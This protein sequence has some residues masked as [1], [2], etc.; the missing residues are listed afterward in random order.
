MQDM[1]TRRY[2]RMKPPEDLLVAWQT[3]TQKA[4]SRVESI[5]LGGLFVRTTDP[6]PRAS[7]LQILLDW[8]T[9]EARA[10]CI[11]RRAEPLR[12]MALEIIGMEPTDR[13]RLAGL[14]HTMQMSSA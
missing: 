14:L 9:G 6:A 1:M 10:R 4:V 2:P 3:A 5:A 11:V 8:R 7:V 12:G 13:I